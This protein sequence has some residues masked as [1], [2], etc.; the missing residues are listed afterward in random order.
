MASLRSAGLK[1]LGWAVLGAA[2][3]AASA[4]TGDGRAQTTPTTAPVGGSETS[5]IVFDFDIPAQPVASALERYGNITRI[6][7]VFSSDLA[8]GRTSTAIKGRYASGEALRRLLGGTGLM[9][10]RHDLGIGET[11]LLREHAPASSSRSD[12]S[13]LFAQEGYAGLLQERIWL[14][15]CAHV[16][17]APGSERLLLQFRID[18]GGRLADIRLLQPT[19]SAGRDGAILDALKRVQVDTPP[20]LLAQQAIIM[21]LLPAAPGSAER[22]CEHG[23][24]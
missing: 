9:A 2:G 21:S 12:R 3:L 5:A 23:A 22:R 14:A 20:V 17:T 13:A 11:W 18:Q 4:W 19:A 15:L 10:E 16:R 6:A 1:G 7:I 8:K 24:S